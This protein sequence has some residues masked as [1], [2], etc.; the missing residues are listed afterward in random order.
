MMTFAN[1]QDEFAELEC[2][3]R[4]YIGAVENFAVEGGLGEGFLRPL[5]RGGVDVCEYA[6]EFRKMLDAYAAPQE[7]R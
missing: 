5:Y 2:R 4:I 7:H 1:L 3:L 6:N